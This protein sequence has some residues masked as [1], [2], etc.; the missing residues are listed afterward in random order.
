MNERTLALF[1]I[2]SRDI[3]QILELFEVGVPVYFL[4]SIESWSKMNKSFR[5]C[6]HKFPQIYRVLVPPLRD[7]TFV[8]GS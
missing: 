5:R 7:S 2:S 3:E 4:I 6:R 1:T 8:A